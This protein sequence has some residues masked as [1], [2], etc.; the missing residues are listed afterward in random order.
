MQHSIGNHITIGR[1]FSNIIA[2]TILTQRLAKPF[3]SFVAH[4]TGSIT[5]DY[6]FNIGYPAS[7][8]V[9]HHDT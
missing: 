6:T 5:L 8:S 1:I 3:Y 7:S 9:K 2:F 4:L